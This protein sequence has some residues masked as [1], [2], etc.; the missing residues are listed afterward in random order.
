[1][2]PVRHGLC[3][4]E[5]LVPPPAHPQCPEQC[6]AHSKH[7]INGCLTA[8]DGLCICTSPSLHQSFLPQASPS[9]VRDRGR[10][11]WAQSP[12]VC[13]FP[14]PNLPAAQQEGVRGRS[15]PQTATSSL[16]AEPYTCGACGIQFQFYNN[17]LEHMQSH[18][19]ERASRQPAPPPPQPWERQRWQSQ[20]EGPREG[21][22]VPGKAHRIWD[23]PSGSP[24]HPY[25][26]R[27][28]GC[29]CSGG[30]G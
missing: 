8:L 19:G 11:D 29:P 30:R 13:G 24:S 23:L 3:P 15:A 4:R 22:A 25:N 7:S 18:A 28:G 12:S 5:C 10:S 26:T 14:V 21:H 2:E 20:P 17:L 6:L 1:M 27:C 9:L 16:P